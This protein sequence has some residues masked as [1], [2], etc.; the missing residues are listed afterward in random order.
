MQKLK[1]L[2]LLLS[3]LALNINGQNNWEG[4]IFAGASNYLGDLVVPQFTLKNSKPAFGIFLKNQ[5][6]PRFGL[7]MSLLYGQIEGADLNWD[8]N[9]E[10]GAAFS[11]SIIELAVMGEYELFGHRRFD[12]NGNF[13][14][15]FSPYFFSGVGV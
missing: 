4:G 15:T 2:T 1:L 6:Q 7:R 14:K 10:R 11:S 8:R 3:I 9:V 5:M 13:K 12:D